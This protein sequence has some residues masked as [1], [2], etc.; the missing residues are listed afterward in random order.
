VS[1]IGH[2]YRRLIHAA[3]SHQTQEVTMSRRIIPVLC[4]LAVAVVPATALAQPAQDPS[5][6]VNRAGVAYGDTKYDLQ[7]QRDQKAPAGG[8]AYEQAIS[9]D[10]K[11]NLPRAIAPAPA[12]PSTQVTDVDRIGSLTPEQLAAA[13]GT[14]KPAAPASVPTASHDNTTDGWQIAALAQA[15]LLA[16][17]ALG[18]AV[19]ISGRARSRRLGT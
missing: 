6:A 1:D 5:P 10:T 13:Y 8:T 7:N 15:A 9:G 19:L 18:A 4:A 3:L 2:T 12:A 17:C 11:G 16:A 14:T